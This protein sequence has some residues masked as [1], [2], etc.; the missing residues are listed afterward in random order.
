MPASYRIHADL[1]LVYVRYAG[2]VSVQD[3][4]DVFDRFLQDPQNRPGARQLI[5]LSE[6]TGFERDLVGLMA[7]QARK[8]EAFVPPGAP[9]TLLVYL[10]LSRRGLEMARLIERSWR[11]L[12]QVVVSVQT[13]VGAAL[14]VLGLAPDVAVRLGLRTLD[15]VEPGKTRDKG[16]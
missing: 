9:Q 13:E 8:A 4:R 1:G 2:H 15:G 3:T 16:G 14:D 10:A 6:V 11:G 12:G 5:D 7:L